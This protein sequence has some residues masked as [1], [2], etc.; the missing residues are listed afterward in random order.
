MRSFTVIGRFDVRTH[1]PY[2]VG[3][4]AIAEGWHVCA[5]PTDLEKLLGIELGR[6]QVWPA[7]AGAMVAEV[8]PRAVEPPPPAIAA[9]SP[10]IGLVM[11]SLA[12]SSAHVKGMGARK[13]QKPSVAILKARIAGSEQIAAD[14]RPIWNS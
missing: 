7:R 12:G 4:Q 5:L 3:R 13:A 6:E 9:G 2:F 11:A 1:L 8:A 10:S 14:G